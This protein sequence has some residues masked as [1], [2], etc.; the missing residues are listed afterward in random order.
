MVVLHVLYLEMTVLHV[1]DS[2]LRVDDHR[3]HGVLS[4]YG[5]GFRVY[6]LEFCGFGFSVERVQGLGFRV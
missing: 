6:G 3:Q 4:T 2:E 5:S 1:Q